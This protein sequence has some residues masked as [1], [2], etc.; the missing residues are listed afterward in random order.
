MMP[1][2]D[3]K[4][5]CA[6]VDCPSADSRQLG[7][8]SVMDRPSDNS[9]TGRQWSDWMA[10]AQA[11][12][13]HAYDAL[14]RGCMPFIERV[15][16]K[17]GVPT[18]RVDDVVQEVLITVHRARHTY[19]PN[20]SFSAWLYAIAQRRAIDA[21]RRTGRQ[22]RREMYASLAIDLHPDPTANTGAGW[23]QTDLQRQIK[24]AMSGLSERQ[25]EAVDHLALQEQTLD[26]AARATG[27]STGALKVNLHRALNALRA[28]LGGKE[29]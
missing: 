5:S 14:L 10:R 1:T 29:I 22:M 18:D 16:R 28:Q 24:N 25:R 17:Q 3:S 7:A 19:D 21:L 12:D 11:G 13:R 15:A 26:E 27:R 8:M 23:E 4:R 9:V 6:H 2:L 20:R